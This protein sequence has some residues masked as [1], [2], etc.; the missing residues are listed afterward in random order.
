MLSLTTQLFSEFFW[1]LSVFLGTRIRRKLTGNQF[2]RVL[3]RYAQEESENA[4]LFLRLGV[5]STLIRHEN[6]LFRKRSSNRTNLK[7]PA[8][9]FSADRKYLKSELFKNDDCTIIRGLEIGLRVQDWV[10]LRLFESSHCHITYPFH[11]MSYPLCLK[12]AWRSR[13]LEA[14]L[15]WT[16]KIILVLNLVIVVQSKRPY[17]IKNWI[18]G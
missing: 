1:W 9:R 6:G 16:S 18:I 10:R 5:P 12:S 14:S 17:N 3:L 11:L 4:A 2:T 8:F 7:T 13:A 15:V